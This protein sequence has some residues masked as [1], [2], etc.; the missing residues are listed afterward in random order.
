MPDVWQFR[1]DPQD[2]GVVYEWFDPATDA[3]KWGKA[4]TTRTWSTQGLEPKLDRHQNIGWYR[5]EVAIPPKFAGRKINLNLFNPGDTRGTMHVWVNGQFATYEVFD[6]HWW[7]GRD[8]ENASTVLYSLDI[9]DHLRRGENNS[10]VIRLDSDRKWD[11]FDR[12]LLLWA[13]K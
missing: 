10:I 4:H 8:P 7:S 2:E 11:G 9:T 3:S 12:R 6:L 13:P 5:T 1:L